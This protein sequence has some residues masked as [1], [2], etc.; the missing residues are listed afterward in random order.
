MTPRI[1]H[2]EVQ[3]DDFL[4]ALHAHFDLGGYNVRAV[5][6]EKFVVVQIGTSPYAQS[7]GPT[8]LTVSLQKVEDGISVEIGKQA[9]LGVAA[10]FGKT[11]LAALMNPANL[12]GRIDDLAQDFTSVQ[13]TDEV[14]KVLDETARSLNA[15]FDL[16]ERLRKYVCNYCGT[17]NPLGEPS[18]I[19]CGAPLG[20]IQPRT[21]PYCGYVITT[22]EAICPNCGK[23]ISSLK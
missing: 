5:G 21:C 14:D 6:D 23:P 10:S 13:L 8:S 4:S 2:G 11:A 16:S 22:K 9:M 19:A 15:S 17:P 7:G 3:I 18:C 20:D 12:F 1:Y